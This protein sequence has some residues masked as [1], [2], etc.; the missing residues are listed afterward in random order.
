VSDQPAPDLGAIRARL[1]TLHVSSR[2]DVRALLAAYDAQA[3]QLAAYRAALE[4][5]RD[6]DPLTGRVR[7]GPT[8]IGDTALA[9]AN[10]LGKCQKIAAGAVGPGAPS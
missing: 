1:E 8:S 7:P 4:T 2:A 9:I 3:A 10:G 6:L 5:I